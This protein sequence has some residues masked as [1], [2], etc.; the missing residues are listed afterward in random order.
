MPRPRKYDWEDKRDICYKLYVER[1]FSGGQIVKYFAE[2]FNIPISELPGRNQ[3]HA[4]FREWGF[5][6]RKPRFSPDE[7]AQVTARLHELYNQ[8]LSA[9][10]IQNRLNEEGWELDDYYFRKFRKKQ[11]LM[12]RAQHGYQFQ[13]DWPSSDKRKRTDG[14]EE[15]G[16]GDAIDAAIGGPAKKQRPEPP[17]L[18][19]DEALRREQRKTE[20]EIQSDHLL[21]TKKRRRR[22]R[23]FGHLPPDA[24]DLGP[25]YSSETSLDE[26]KAF[27]QLDNEM[28]TSVRSQFESICR[29]MEIMKPTLCA[30]GQWQ[31]AKDR[32]IRDNTHLSA[33]LH[34]LQPEIDK[35]LNAVNCICSDVTKRM[36][37]A[38]KSITIADANNMLGLNPAQSKDLRRV[39]YEILEADHFTTVFACGKE[40]VDELRQR[41]IDQ[42]P[43][44]QRA[45]ASGDKSLTRAVELLAKDARKRYCDD[46][47]RKDPSKR[48]WQK[49]EHYGPGPGPA[50]GPGRAKSKKQPAT[51]PA[52]EP[53]SQTQHNAA[54]PQSLIPL[55][56]SWN[57]VEL[58]PFRSTTIA[59]MHPPINF[60]LDPLLAP[61]HGS[62]WPPTSS[63]PAPQPQ[64]QPGPSRTAVPAY[65]R[66]APD[67]QLVGH[68]PRMWLGKLVAPTVQALHT[69]ATSK[70]GAAYVAK[71]NGLMKNLDG[72][73]DSW[74]IEN[75]D[76]LA[77][78]LQEAGEKATFSAVLKGGYA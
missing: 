7:E 5:P 38:S 34:P 50:Q 1:E 2:H 36:R 75:D 10:E 28:Y 59:D 77:V 30:E 27:L 43:I 23:G 69:A 15:E 72:T 48:Q 63:Q 24:P 68:H 40:H 55:P 25:R 45:W 20:L 71:I 26:C 57:G 17:P 56:P 35:R 52:T 58:P 13:S 46:Q 6:T 70:A 66:L 41:W 29:D 67:S 32:L 62:P 44:L 12:L 64:A 37:T 14:H 42:S 16:E 54:R 65:F 76:E 73:E 60:D 9:G 78:Y 11:G 31:A 4:K 49:D 39:M 47:C 3:F 61:T 33:V 53:E 19:P 8:N 22:I 18:P 21:Q 51:E 74:L